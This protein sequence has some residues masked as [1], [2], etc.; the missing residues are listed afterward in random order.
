MKRERAR[1]SESVLEQETDSPPGPVIHPL[2]DPACTCEG[3]GCLACC[4]EA[5]P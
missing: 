5:L 1:E 2:A 3:L 4:G